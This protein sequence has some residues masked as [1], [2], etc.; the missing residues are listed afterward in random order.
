M[1]RRE[2]HLLLIL[3]AVLLGVVYLTPPGASAGEDPLPFPGNQ[4]RT[5]HRRAPSAD[6]LE[7]YQAL[8]TFAGRDL[9][10]RWDEET[11]TPR[12][13]FGRLSRPFLGAPGESARRFVSEQARLIVPGALK[14]GALPGALMDPEAA[15]LRVARVIRRDKVDHVSL[16]QYHGDLP[17]I[18][19]GYTVSLR[20]RPG[21]GGMVLRSVVSAMGSFFPGIPA[22]FDAA[23][24]VEAEEALRIAMDRLAPRSKPS[25]PPM[26]K[27]VI[28]PLN[29][30]YHL[31]WQVDF[32]TKEPIGRWRVYVDARK[33]TILEAVDRI[34]YGDVSGDVWRSNPIRDAG[35]VSTLPLRDAYVVRGGT[36]VVTDGAGYYDDGGAATV[37]S[38][39]VGPFVRALNDDVPEVTYTGPPDLVWSYPPWDTHFDEVNVFYHVNLFH[40]YV[41]NTL[42]F[43]GTDT[44]L[45]A[46][47]HIGNNYNN[48]FYDGTGIAFGDGDGVV[49][50]NFAQD[51]VIY[52]EYG[53][54][55]FDRA[56]SLGGGR[57]EQGGMNEGGADYFACSFSDDPVL[58]EGVRIGGS[59]RNID[60]K[61]FTPPR[62]YPDY[63]IANNY[64]PHRGGE[65]W[66]G[67][68]W[69]IRKI[70][71]AASCDPIAFD[72][73][74]YMPPNPGFL[75]GRDGMVQSDI[76]NNYGVHKL[77]IEQMMFERGIGPAPSTDPFVRII[78]NPPVAVAPVPIYFDAIVVDDGT[79]VSFD[80]D[81]GDG[82]VA[83][84]AVAAASHH[85]T[86]DGVYNVSLVVTDD[87]GATGS[88]SIMVYLLPQGQIVLTPEEMDVGFVRSDELWTNFF[89]DDDVYAGGLAGFDYHGAALFRLPFLAGG[90]SDIV[91]DSVTLELMGQ[92]AAA[93][94]PT[95]GIWAVKM[96]TQ[97]IDP[98][99]RNEGY[100]GI[101]SAQTLFTVE[102]PLTNSD[103][104]SGASN[105]FGVSSSQLPALHNRLAAG[106]VSFRVDGP[107]GVNNLFSWDSG[108][109]LFGEDPAATR[110][111][112]VL[113]IQYTRLRELGDVNADG[114]VDETDARVVAE[115][116]LGIR[117]L[118]PDDWSNVD[119]DRNGVLD[120]RDTAAILAK[121]AG[122]L[123]F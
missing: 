22:S 95:G 33:R 116:I 87:T 65:V 3:A 43:Y 44:Q 68:V 13:L 85:Y 69:D 122:Q 81:F 34:I 98:G 37:T 100:L 94:G 36:T 20:R 55:L 60:N 32:R 123:D 110:V 21:P 57:S 24:A 17:V 2:S 99:W 91:F 56:I 8:R 48:A 39:L 96:L 15:P 84:T 19:G 90:A 113:R 35:V 107:Y 52:H 67:A 119:A 112:P 73:L 47:V 4:I 62:I 5:S 46:M 49:F 38:A 89:G 108:Y 105:T 77:I 93:K 54:F 71:G 29:G 9:R 120:S 28:Y 115:A 76:D 27:L 111:K 23:P 104:L 25:E 86:T 50:S 59:L 82:T 16:L 78:P 79:P 88:W 31:A 14:P 7:A 75:D 97:E 72:G 45:P 1:R 61:T 18:R 51:D 66:G 74:F 118:T 101:L 6:Q 12:G 30:A 64:E 103:L 83:T 92:D 114:V 80:W 70:I 109:D 42:G 40:D 63:L 26:E 117:T 41:R 53:H 102:P 106:T 10:A 58:A 11:G 121:A